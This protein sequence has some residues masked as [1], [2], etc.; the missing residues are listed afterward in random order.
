MKRRIRK[1][2]RPDVQ[3]RVVLIAVVV[4]CLALIVHFQAG[5]LALST[6]SARFVGKT[7]PSLI[8]SELHH[9]MITRLVICAS[10]MIP[11]A[12]AAG[13][14]YSFK[15]CGPIYRFKQYF[16]ELK[17]GRWDKPCAIRKGDDLQDLCGAIN[18][19]MAPLQDF[20]RQNQAVLKD[21]EGLAAKG[22]WSTGSDGA[23]AMR[24]LMGRV[25][26]LRAELERRLPASLQTRAQ[27]TEARSEKEAVLAS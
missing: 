9:V 21:V 18:D 2:V 3:L 12:V 26:A 10:I 17:Q 16:L 11:V 7:D 1:L 22:A 20:A 27:E 14:L 23:G 24:D 13:V 19:A 25:S 5:L 15:F 8:F 6:T 4:T